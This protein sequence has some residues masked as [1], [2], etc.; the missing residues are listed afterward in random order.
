MR[1]RLITI[2]LLVILSMGTNQALGATS[3]KAQKIIYS[4]ISQAS[5][6]EKTHSF[7]YSSTSKL[8]VTAKA[9]SPAICTLGKATIVITGTPGVCRIS[10]KQNGNAY[11]LP[12]RTV[13]IEF[14]VLGTNLIDFQLPGALLLSLGSFQVSATTSSKLPVLLVSTT[15]TTCTIADSLLNLLQIGTCTIVASQGGDE[16]IPPA[17]PITRNVEISANRV[18]ADLPD[19][20]SGFQIKPVY[21]VPSD[22]TDNSYDTNGYIAGILDGG[23]NYL[24]GQL[25]L[26]IP[27]DRTSTGYDIQ[28]L[29]SKYSTQYLSTHESTIYKGDSDGK[30]LLREIGAMENPGENRKDYIFFIEVPGFEGKYC[31]YA[32]MPGMT[33]VVSLQNI[34]GIGACA[35]KSDPYFENFT[36]KTWVHELMHNFGVDHTLDD[37]CDLMAGGDT[38]GTCNSTNRYTMDKERTRYVGASTQGQDIL[39]LRVWEGYTHDQGLKADCLINPVPRSDGTEYAYCPT[40]S[41]PIGELHSCWNSVSSV[42]LEESIGGIWTSLGNGNYASSLWGGDLPKQACADAGYPYAVWKEV[43]VNSPGLRHYRW[44]VNG[45]VNESLDVIWVD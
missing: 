38:L 15:P 25:G 13:L 41:R 26:K 9:L 30:V 7:R 39:K 21:V 17:D 2:C 28:F 19:T 27:I 40:G 5:I 42:S 3:K 1:N 31:G 11:F 34:P 43:T 10:L 33:A 14:K 22:A 45:R 4:P 36:S 32:A 18:M 37:P 29:K 24:K 23:E 8:V 16:L 35:G 44:V 6:S 12:A 20:V